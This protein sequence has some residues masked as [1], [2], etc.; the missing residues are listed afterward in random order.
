MAH[1]DHSLSGLEAIITGGTD[2]IGRETVKALALKGASVTFLGRDKAKGDAVIN[3]CRAA[4]AHSVRF[5]PCDLSR[6]GSIHS[7]ADTI[8]KF[9]P[10]IDILVNNAG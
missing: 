9:V 4:G 5:F 10:K 8:L 3:A 1:F 6:Q 7:V 2:G